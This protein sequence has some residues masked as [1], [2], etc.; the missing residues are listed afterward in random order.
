[1]PIVRIE[2][3]PGCSAELKADMA[4]EI[5][6]EVDRVGG[7]KPEATTVVLVEVPPHDW[8]VASK[9]LGRAQ[10]EAR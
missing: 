3:F 2:L 7:I 4:R 10:Q 8:A 9:P 6:G 1:M 5:T